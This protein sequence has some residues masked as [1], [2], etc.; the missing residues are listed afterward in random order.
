MLNSPH[1]GSPH[2]PFNEGE[3]ST[4]AVRRVRR[5]LEDRYAGMRDVKFLRKA[6]RLN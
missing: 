3:K 5:V 1:T 4:S 2:K 6:L